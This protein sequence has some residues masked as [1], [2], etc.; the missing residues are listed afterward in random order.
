[1]KTN[2]KIVGCLVVTTPLLAWLGC[3]NMKT[4]HVVDR[5]SPATP[6]VIAVDRGYD[7]VGRKW[8]EE[9]LARMRQTKSQRM[10]MA[11]L[12]TSANKSSTSKSSGQST[13]STKANTAVSSSKDSSVSKNS[14]S[15]SSTSSR[16]DNNARQYAALN[17]SASDA[18]SS[19]GSSDSNAT[20]PLK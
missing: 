9:E 13:S 12:D 1:M 5:I 20:R 11:K 3:D 2:L 4:R 6:S 17:D 19:R 16:S 18:R 7:T 14:S 10:E 8:T 15:G